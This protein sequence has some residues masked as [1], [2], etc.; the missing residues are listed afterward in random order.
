MQT[1]WGWLPAIYL[2][3]GGTSVGALLVAAA[4]EFSGKRYQYNF[5]PTSLVGATVSGPLIILG[6]LVLIFKL[7]AGLREPWRIFYMFTHFSSVMTWGVWII[8]FFI[9]ISLVYGFL[10]V[11]DTFPAA[12]DWLRARRWLRKAK[13]LWNLPIRRTKRLFAGV[14]LVL[15]VGVAA[16][17]GSLISAVGPAIPFWST[18]VLPFIPVPMM[19]V[20]FLV[21]ALSAGL[22]LTVDLAAT[23]AVGP[24]EQRVKSLPWIQMALIGVQ[25][26][27]LGMLLI[28]ALVDGGSAAQS[29]LEIIVGTYAVVFWVLIVF[30]G[31]LFPFIV[32]AC[33]AGLG[34]HSLVSRVGSGVGIVVASLFLRYL[35]LASGIYAAL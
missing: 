8:T 2:F 12:W 5:C 35:I 6:A 28:T 17:Q 19:P 13:F 16:E 22:G 14:G 4:F 18:R 15:A 30:P 34:R 9:T 29:A 10:E 1:A 23:L 11:M 25:T 31:L 33:A 27:L 24:M 7:G 3:L 32:Y 21:S 26:L 20:L